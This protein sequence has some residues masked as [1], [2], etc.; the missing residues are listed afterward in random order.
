MAD[1]D[2]HLQAAQ[3]SQPTICF[4]CIDS[5]TQNTTHY[6]LLFFH[7]II[8]IIVPLLYFVKTIMTQKSSTIK[9]CQFSI[10]N[11]PVTHIDMHTELTCLITVITVI[12]TVIINNNKHYNINTSAL[13]DKQ[14]SYIIIHTAIIHTVILCS[15]QQ[16]ITY[17]TATLVWQVL[18]QHCLPFCAKPEK[19][20]ITEQCNLEGICVVMKPR[21]ASIL[22][23]LTFDSVN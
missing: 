3:T 8:C 5:P 23:N 20:L 6:N 22:V 2:K 9:Q 10:M 13:H 19:L 21:N 14:N 1:E 15:W 16:V 18:F 12:I 17:T 4:L 11:Q 7:S